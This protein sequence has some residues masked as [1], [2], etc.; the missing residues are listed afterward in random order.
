MTDYYKELKYKYDSYNKFIA[1][2]PSA[3]IGIKYRF[4]KSPEKKLMIDDIMSGWEDDENG[5]APWYELEGKDRFH[6]CVRYWCHPDEQYYKSH[7][8][9]VK[10]VNE[11]TG[12]VSF[13]EDGHGLESHSLYVFKEV[14]DE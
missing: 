6:S 4:D 9:T 1:D 3:F 8:F 2:M 11:E 12:H 5:D 10:S 7:V 14:I 13:E